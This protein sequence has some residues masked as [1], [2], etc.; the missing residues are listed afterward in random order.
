LKERLLC[1]AVFSVDGT[2]HFESAVRSMSTSTSHDTS[3]RPPTRHTYLAI[4]QDFFSIQEYIL[5]QYNASLHRDIGLSNGRSNNKPKNTGDI[6]ASSLGVQDFAPAAVM[7]YTDIYQLRGV[8]QPV[9]Y[10]SGIEYAQGLIEAF[11][12]SALQIGLWLNGTVGC[13]DILD[14]KLDKQIY[15][16]FDF[17]GRQTS[18]PKIFLRVGYEFDNPWFGYSDSPSTYQAA[19]R[20]LVLDCELQLSRGICRHRVAF[21]WHSW[22]APRTVPSLNAFYP[23]DDVVD[24]VGVSIFQQLYPWANVENRAGDGSNNFSGGTLQQV[25]EVLEFAKSC[26][27]PIMIAES[28]PFGG[29]HVAS[30]DMAQG[31]I[32]GS[33]SDAQNGD[34]LW[35]L[36]YQKTIDLIEEYDIA[37]WSYINCDWESQPLWHGVGFGDTRISSSKLV[38]ARWWENVLKNTT[39][40]LNQM[41]CTNTFKNVDNTPS[42]NVP[43]ALAG[44]VGP[45][46]LEEGSQ[47]L[48]PTKNF[49]PLILIL[50]GAMIGSLMASL[51]LNRRGRREFSVFEDRFRSLRVV[52]YGSMT[53]QSP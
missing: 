7:T 34:I 4:G 33:T 3:C 1:S 28:T 46:P 16:L 18:I 44:G 31:Y 36:W 42:S 25:I 35:D 41:S 22:A 14:G 19:F 38:M 49:I 32:D 26:D 20:K 8:D 47:Y 2:E 24:W 45:I 23:G 51:R 15:K 13:Q 52:H 30:T 37:M 10:G 39:R 40:F 6:V 12:H 50:A 43:K 53:M 9:D 11:P 29:I 21:V 17:V 48:M 27:K 5:S